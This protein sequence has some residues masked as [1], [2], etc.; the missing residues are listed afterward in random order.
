MTWV[1]NAVQI[2]RGDDNHVPLG[3][4]ETVSELGHHLIGVDDPTRI[5]DEVRLVFGRFDHLAVQ[6]L[7]VD[8]FAI[9]HVGA[10][11]FRCCHRETGARPDCHSR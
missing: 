9:T 10:D 1:F 4:I 7:P 11:A 3:Q 6:V 5:G 2:D 8:V